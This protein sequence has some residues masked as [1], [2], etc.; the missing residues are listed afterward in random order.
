MFEILDHPSDVGILAR[1]P[2]REEALLELSR[3]LISIMADT[4]GIGISQ[5]RDFRAP[6]PDEPAQVV[7]WLNEILF[8]FDTEGFLPIDL[9]IDSW[10]ERE[11]MG[12]AH[13][14]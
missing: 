7:N 3:G 14:R 12:R 11:I 4:E 13:G 6:G 5:E 10:T 9:Q 2:T 8:F 1:A